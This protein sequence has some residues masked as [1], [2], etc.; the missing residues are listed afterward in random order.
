MSMVAIVFLVFTLNDK[1]I[2]SIKGCRKLWKL[3]L[4]QLILQN[5]MIT[6]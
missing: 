2:K 4:G 3:L 5:I 1:P 6:S